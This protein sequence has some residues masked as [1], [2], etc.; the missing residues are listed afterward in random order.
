MNLIEG[1]FKVV[2]EYE[3]ILKLQSSL[4][5]YFKGKLVNKI[6]S[7]G[8]IEIPILMRHGL[9][10]DDINN[11]SKDID[12]NTIP[13]VFLFPE[14]IREIKTIGIGDKLLNL[15]KKIN[16][17]NKEI[18][19]KLYFTKIYNYPGEL[20]IIFNTLNRLRVVVRLRKFY[21]EK[22]YYILG[23]DIGNL[24]FENLESTIHMAIRLVDEV[25]VDLDIWRLKLKEGKYL[26]EYI[27]KIVLDLLIR[28]GK[29]S[30][31]EEYLEL[32]GHK[33]IPQLLD[34][35]FSGFDLESKAYENDFI[36]YVGIKQVVK[37]GLKNASYLIT[38]IIMLNQ[39]INEILGKPSE[40]GELI[41][42]I[43]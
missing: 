12:K 40:Y 27:G 38:Y 41:K 39:F 21:D 15:I 32:L 14:S 43:V 9:V 5:K 31:K 7:V 2:C 28:M 19:E 37:T 13:T 16:E 4:S 34:L 23:F 17:R 42:V 36:K 26:Y 10:I 18:I 35:I 25:V 30:I 20:N 1:L 33:G 11:G 3:K 29:V 8:K 6:F 24:T 22:P